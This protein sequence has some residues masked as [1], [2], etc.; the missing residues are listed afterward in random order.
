MSDGQTPKDAPTFDGV[1]GYTPMPIGG[2]AVLEGVM[3]RGKK[4]WAVAAR[5]EQGEIHVEQHPLKSANSNKKWPKWPI[6][7]GI[8]TLGQSLVLGTKSLNISAKIAGLEEEVEGKERQSAM[9]A[10][11]IAT[12][13]ALGIA[14]AVAIFILLPSFLTQLILGGA[15][16]GRFVWDLLYGALSLI[17]FLAY[18]YAISLLPDIKRVFQF[19]GA[20]HKVIQVVENAEPLTVE[21]ARKYDTLHTRCGTAFLIMVMALAILVFALVPVDGIATVLGITTDT[22]MYEAVI[23]IVRIASRLLLLPLVAGLA[24]EITVK[25][26]SKNT[27]LGIVKLIMWP[28]LQM[29]RLTTGEPDDDMLEV[30]IAATRAVLAAEQGMI[31]PEQEEAEELNPE[32]ATD[33][34]VE[35]PS[36][37]RDKVLLPHL[38]PQP[39]P[40]GA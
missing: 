29:Q 31:E 21:S 17:I 39:V 23:F 20:E 12:S 24:Y 2:Q 15:A 32:D 16:E 1:T 30:A 14:L 18:V 33:N 40:S 3:M 34:E 35:V 13:V 38:N 8:V 5:D 11:M 25:W 6:I 19:H 26:A 4:V 9:T 28:G 36:E 37:E 22:P 27:H 10:G 7:R